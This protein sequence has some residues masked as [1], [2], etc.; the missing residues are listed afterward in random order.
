MSHPA[1]YGTVDGVSGRP[2]VD[3]PQGHA[4]HVGS[5]AQYGDGVE[6]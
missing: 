3:I 6:V 5:V 1:W 4:R 2:T